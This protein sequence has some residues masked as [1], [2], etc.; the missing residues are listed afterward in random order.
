MDQQ[1]E[2]YLKTK[3]KKVNQNFDS[4]PN[5]ALNGEKNIIGNNVFTYKF[6][7]VYDGF[8]ISLIASGAG[9]FTS[10]GI[11]EHPNR[12]FSDTLSNSEY[13]TQVLNELNELFGKLKTKFIY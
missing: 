2:V 7:I 13:P 9:I 12:V 3:L 6:N 10:L 8:S 5:N 1:I 4:I 11:T